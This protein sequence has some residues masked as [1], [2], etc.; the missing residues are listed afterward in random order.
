MNESSDQNELSTDEKGTGGFKRKDDT[1]INFGALALGGSC[2]L[3]VSAAA[4]D[5]FAASAYFPPRASPL[6]GSL[7]LGV[8]AASAD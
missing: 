1:R 2:D 3:E 4:A 8:S 6:G 7:G 5:A